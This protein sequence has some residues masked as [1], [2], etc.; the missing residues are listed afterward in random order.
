MRAL[1]SQ[2]ASAAFSVARVRHLHNGKI[3]LDIVA[4]EGRKKVSVSSPNNCDG[5]MGH[6]ARNGTYENLFFFSLL[7]CR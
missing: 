4:Q 1:A 3:T 5:A 2:P 7:P 6:S